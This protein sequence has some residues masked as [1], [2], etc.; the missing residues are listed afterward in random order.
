MF[1]LCIFFI[2]DS[3]STEEPGNN[4]FRIIFHT[5]L[6][7]ASSQL[8]CFWWTKEYRS[9]LPSRMTLR[10]KNVNKGLDVWWFI[11]S[12][13]LFANS[14]PLVLQTCQ[15]MLQ[16]CPI[17]YSASVLKQ[18]KSWPRRC[19]VRL[20]G[21]CTYRSFYIILSIARTVLR[22]PGNAAVAYLFQRFASQLISFN[23][24]LTDKCE[25]IDFS[26]VCSKLNLWYFPLSVLK[27]AQLAHLVS[28][29]YF[30]FSLTKLHRW[31][32]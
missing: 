25:I 10:V 2:V 30:K 24:I 17:R 12:L 22:Q 29:W 16:I 4:E 11:K 3:C 28:C 5:S 20:L 18:S 13:V 9:L 26:V 7:L 15:R 14:F 27:L 21:L 23:N 31:S 8:K 6:L 19:K 1:D 32:N